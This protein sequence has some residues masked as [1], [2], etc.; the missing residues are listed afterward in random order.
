LLLLDTCTFLW[1]TTGDP[2]VPEAVR[3]R[4]RDQDQQVFLSA[5]S[6]WE[7]CVKFALGRLPLA[8]PPADYVPDRRRR[9]GIV[10]IDLQEADVLAITKLPPLHRDPF[11]RM[12][13]AQAIARGMTLVTPDPG[14]RA[15]P[16]LTWWGEGG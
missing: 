9:L 16:C 3:D 11:D 5:V 12:L 4:L 10:A 6:T 8:A 13:A 15:Y 14:V 7:I 1:W 2:S